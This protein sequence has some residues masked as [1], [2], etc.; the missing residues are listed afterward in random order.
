MHIWCPRF[1]AWLFLFNSEFSWM[2]ISEG[3]W[4]V[5]NFHWLWWKWWG[6]NCSTQV[7]LGFDFHG[8]HGLV[9]LPMNATHPPQP[10]S[11]LLGLIIFPP[12]STKKPWL[13]FG[14]F[15]STFSLTL[16]LTLNCCI[17]EDKNPPNKPQNLMMIL[18]TTCKDSLSTL[19]LTIYSFG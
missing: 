6:I 9:S 12:P 4:W 7:T 16:T 15:V 13:G 5:S 2:V 8:Y 17:E 1:Y 14:I 3:T 19:T 10:S 18:Q 11:F